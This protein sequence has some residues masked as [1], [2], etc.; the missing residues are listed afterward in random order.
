MGSGLRATEYGLLKRCVKVGVITTDFGRTLSQAGVRA[1]QLVDL[2]N[3]SHIT[4]ISAST[5]EARRRLGWRPDRFTVVHTGNMGAKQGLET[6]VEA[7]RLSHASGA[8]IDFVLMGDGN[9]RAALEAMAANVPGLRILPPTSCED[10]PYVLAAADVLL[11]NELPGVKMMSLPSKL[12][13]YAAAGKPILAAVDPDG[14]TAHYLRDM[15]FGHVVGSGSGRGLLDA[16][17]PAEP[18]APRLEALADASR[19]VHRTAFDKGAAY[20]RYQ[21]FAESM[22]VS[23]KATA[24]AVSYRRNLSV[25]PQ[26]QQPSLR[27]AVAFSTPA[28]ADVH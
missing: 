7:A 4:S 20:G 21:A 13:S 19:R 17:R 16:A 26:Q 25:I 23:P 14:I 24:Q 28:V 6:V 12:T 1:D 10:Y 8:G 27:P 3:F 2:P 15:R 5:A 11:I 9:Q 18:D 22:L